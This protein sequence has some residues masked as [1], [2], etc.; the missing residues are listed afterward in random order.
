M[1]NSIT[2]YT[3]EGR[4]THRPHSL[5]SCLFQRSKMDSARPDRTSWESGQLLE[6]PLFLAEDSAAVQEQGGWLTL[7]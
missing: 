6:E 1:T 4:A 7:H 5:R 2:N 3:V